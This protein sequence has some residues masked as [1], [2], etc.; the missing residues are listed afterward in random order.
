MSIKN[1][2]LT[3]FAYHWHTNSRIFEEVVHLDDES[4]RA[5]TGY[6]RGSI[7]DLLLHILNTDRSWRLALETGQQ[8]GFL[9]TEQF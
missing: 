9:P 1:N 8:Q 7:H 4:F 2:Y 3:L 5:P 6:G